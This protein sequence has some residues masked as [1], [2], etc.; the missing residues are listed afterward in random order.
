MICMALI[1]E[2]TQTFTEKK[3]RVTLSNA[4][5]GGGGGI[6]FIF[7]VLLDL[8]DLFQNF[9]TLAIYELAIKSNRV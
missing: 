4:L 3:V 5:L 2:N 9:S 6:F 8:L 1:K 7:D